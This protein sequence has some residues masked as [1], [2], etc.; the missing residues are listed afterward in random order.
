KAAGR[1]LDR[2]GLSHR[3]NHLPEQLSGG[4]R[5]R[6]AVARALVSKPALLLA[7]EPTGEL[8]ST[9]AEKLVELLL[10]LHRELGQTLVVATHDSQLAS[11]CRRL[12]EMKDGRIVTDREAPRPS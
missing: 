12:L 11:R 8:D 4:E 3:R 5:Q 6:V 10:S 1:W 2:L 9:N 7:D